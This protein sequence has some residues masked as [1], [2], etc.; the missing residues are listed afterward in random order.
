MTRRTLSEH[1][2]GDRRPQGRAGHLD[3][4]DPHH[5]SALRSRRT[6]AA[7]APPP[8]TP[9]SGGRSS[10]RHQPACSMA[11]STRES[12]VQGRRR[13]RPVRLDRSRRCQRNS[14]RS[15][16]DL[17]GHARGSLHARRGRRLV[18]WV[19]TP[20]RFCPSFASRAGHPPPPAPIRSARFISSLARCRRSPR[21]RAGTWSRST[22]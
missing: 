21:P 1:R 20:A 18:P 19:T 3:G 15:L 11:F 5:R 16:H 10:W 8:K 9:M 12:H 2:P 7:T 17:A 14:D 13:D 22:T 6:S 4:R